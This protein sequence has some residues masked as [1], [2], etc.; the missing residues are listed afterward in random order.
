M[1]KER[2]NSHLLFREVSFIA[3]PL[4]VFEVCLLTHR[5]NSHTWSME[6]RRERALIEVQKKP[7]DNPFYHTLFWHFVQSL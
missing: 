5:P 1:E 7:M 6:Q 3:G 2:E 4:N